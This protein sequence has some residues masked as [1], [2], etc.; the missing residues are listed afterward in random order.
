LKTTLDINMFKLQQTAPTVFEKV[1]RWTEVAA[2]S[3]IATTIESGF[4]WHVLVL[5]PS[6]DDMAFCRGHMIDMGVPKSVLA[7]KAS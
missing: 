3:G 7:S 1:F 5:L 2:A 4:S 6:E